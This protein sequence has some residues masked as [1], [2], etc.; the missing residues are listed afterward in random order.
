MFLDT[1]LSCHPAGYAAR[2]EDVVAVT[3]QPCHVG[4]DGPGVD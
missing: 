2:S 1:R 4:G 3:L